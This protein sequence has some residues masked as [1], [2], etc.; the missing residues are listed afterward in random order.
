[1]KKSKIIFCICLLLILCSICIV[2]FGINPQSLKPNTSGSQEI[3]QRANPILGYMQTIGI[4]I[5]VGAVIVVGIKFVTSS[6][7]GKAQL[8]E[9]FV[10]LVIGI[11]IILGITTIL[12]VIASTLEKTGFNG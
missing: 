1:M 2:S 8:K 7:E 4:F 11:V 3:A 6:P 9:Q 12:R 10:P 5:A